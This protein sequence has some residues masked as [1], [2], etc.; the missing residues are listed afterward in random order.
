MSQVLYDA[1]P[2]LLRMNPFGSLLL[3]L[4]LVGG[5]LIATPPVAAGLGAALLIPASLISLAG[6]RWRPWPSS[7]CW[8]G[9][10]RPR[11]IIWSS[12]RMRSSGPT[13]S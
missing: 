3:I 9:S 7:G 4:G 6:W 8:C 10:F 13:A 11:W 12:S 5:V 1:S 2:S